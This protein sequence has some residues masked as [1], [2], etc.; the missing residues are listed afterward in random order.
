VQP[1]GAALKLLLLL[2]AFLCLP[3]PLPAL[4][5]SFLPVCLVFCLAQHS[6]VQHSTAQHS[7][8]P[9]HQ[10]DVPLPSSSMMTRELEVA[11]CGTIQ[12]V[13]ADV[14]YMQMLHCDQAASSQHNRES[15]TASNG[16]LA[17]RSAA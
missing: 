10:V 15:G 14:Q 13:Q 9:A 11:P 1:A 17:A 3:H 6:T 4:Q 8:L 2:I 16:Q 5:S 7:C 12:A